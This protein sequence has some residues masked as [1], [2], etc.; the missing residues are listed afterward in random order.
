MTHLYDGI[1]LNPKKKW[2]I[3]QQKRHRR[4]LNAYYVKA[5]NLKSVHAVLF[6]LYDIP[7]K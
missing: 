6:Q 5:S 7:E 4:N 3:K 2:A 1:L